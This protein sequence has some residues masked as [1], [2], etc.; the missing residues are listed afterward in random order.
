[1]EP[2]Y[3]GHGLLSQ[4]CT[5]YSEIGAPL[6]WVYVYLQKSEALHVFGSANVCVCI[7]VA[8]VFV[9]VCVCV[10]VCVYTVDTVCLLLT[11]CR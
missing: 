11:L 10:C 9:C 2:L 5:N 4:L 3:I 6:C 7:S 8:N 1:M